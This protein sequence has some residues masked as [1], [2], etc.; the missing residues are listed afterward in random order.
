MSFSMPP[1]PTPVATSSSMP[2]PPPWKLHV[3]I[4]P[5]QASRAL[6]V[7]PRMRFFHSTEKTAT[8]HEFC[9]SVQKLYQ[10]TYGQ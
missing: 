4:V 10:Q 2:P 7:E 9:D 5:D 3:H 1:P 6:F 8:I